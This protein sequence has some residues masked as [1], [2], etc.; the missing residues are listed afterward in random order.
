MNHRLNP[1]ERNI[2][3]RV[4]LF[5]GTFNPVH[6]G[7]LRT[8]L[9][10]KEG[11]GLDRVHFIPAANPPH[12]DKKE[13][14]DDSHRFAMLSLALGDAPGFSASDVELRRPGLSYTIDTVNRL[15]RDWPDSTQ[16]YLIVGDDAFMEIDTWKDYR[17]IFKTI[18]LIVMSRPGSSQA[19]RE[20]GFQGIEAHMKDRISDAYRTDGNR[21]TFVHD[22]W[23]PVHLCT[24]T[25]LAVSATTIRRIIREGRSI[26]YLVPD[27]V[28]AYIDDKGLYK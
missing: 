20:D 10:V 3:K 21:R 24:V 12:K 27:A 19:F 23:Q 26:R 28:A 9:E 18:S 6:F 22:S 11:F 16:C 13:L 4:G 15:I 14:A 17:E 1:V 7:H 8:A 2:L 5:G 25:S